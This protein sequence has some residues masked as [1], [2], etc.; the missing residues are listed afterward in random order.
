MNRHDIDISAASISRYPR[1]HCGKSFLDNK[2]L[3]VQVYGRL[4]NGIP[5]I[6]RA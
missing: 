1:S 6:N 4:A 3:K 2:G 5:S